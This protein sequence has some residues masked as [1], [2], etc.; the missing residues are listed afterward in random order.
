MIILKLG[1]VTEINTLAFPA[2][3]IKSLESI[4]YIYILVVANVRE[5]LLT[6]FSGY[7]PFSVRA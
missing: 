6:H 2:L 7:F 4:R 5:G 1:V 3:N